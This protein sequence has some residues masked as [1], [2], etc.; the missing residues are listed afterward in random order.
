MLT[1]IDK[2]H[3]EH[4]YSTMDD[5]IVT[6]GETALRGNHGVERIALPQEK[7]TKRQ[8][9]GAAVAGG[10]AGLLL[11]GPVG[12]VVV[13]GGAAMCATSRGKAGSVARSSGDMMASAGDRLKKL[14]Q[15][16]H[17]VNK[18]SRGI[19]KGCDWVSHQLQPKARP[20]QRPD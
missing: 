14:D 3:Y 1:E 11:A 18:T 13:A 19:V 2:T 10:L 5:E 6:E 12:C 9:G 15:K 20:A 16:H 7:G 17:V 8:V 4:Q